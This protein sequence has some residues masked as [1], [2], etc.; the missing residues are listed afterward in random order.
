M[1]GSLEWLTAPVR[2]VRDFVDHYQKWSAF[3]QELEDAGAD[4]ERILEQL[5][6]CNGDV[7][8]LMVSAPA[9]DASLLHRLMTTLGIDASEIEAGIRRDLERV[10]AGCGHKRE[11]RNDLDRGEAKARWSG[12]CDNRVNLE[13]VLVEQRRGL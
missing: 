13:A 7:R 5:R 6:R 11:C 3:L 12:Y 2:A 10:C 8:K 9:S 4:G 1:A